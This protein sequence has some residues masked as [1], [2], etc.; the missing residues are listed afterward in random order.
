MLFSHG[1]PLQ[2]DRLTVFDY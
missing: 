1:L 2:L